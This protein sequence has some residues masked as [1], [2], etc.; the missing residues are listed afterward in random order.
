MATGLSA[1]S[2]SPANP[3]TGVLP[4][5]TIRDFLYHFPMKTAAVLLVCLTSLFPCLAF[6]QDFL[7]VAEFSGLTLTPVGSQTNMSVA[8]NSQHQ[9][10]YA[11]EGNYTHLPI[12]TYSAVGEILD[13]ALSAT[14]FRGVWYNSN[15][16]TFQGNGFS[17][18]GIFEQPV[19]ES[20]GYLLDPG[21]KLFDSNQPLSQSMAAF[22]SAEDQ[23][24]FLAGNKIH[25]HD[26]ATGLFLM[27][28]T[29]SGVSGVGSSVNPYAILYTGIDSAPY[30][31]VDVYVNLLYLLDENA[32]LVQTIALPAEAN[33]NL[34]YGFAWCNNMLWIFDNIQARWESFRIQPAC[35]PEIY[36]ST[37]QIC[38]GRSYSFGEQEL[39]QSGVYELSYQNTLGCDSLIQL[40]LEVMLPDT[41]YQF[42]Q[43]CSGDSIFI[44][45]TWIRSDT[46]VLE[47]IFTEGGCP[48]FVQHSISL[49]EEHPLVVSA[50]VDGR[51]VSFFDNCSTRWKAAYDFGDGQFAS[52][53]NPVHFY[54]QD[55][56]YT[57]K[58]EAKSEYG[59]SYSDAVLISIESLYSENS[60]A[61]T[62]SR[63]EVPEFPT[64]PDPEFPYSRYIYSLNGQ[65][66]QIIENCTTNVQ[67]APD[68]SN[69]PNGI[70]LIHNIGPS[71]NFT[72]KVVVHH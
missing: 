29:I 7:P 20:T 35:L 40:H 38:Q 58:V 3:L 47:S 24:L 1:L 72:E 67:T 19:D 39:D 23:L 21:V 62:A 64:E 28:K 69:I 17:N 11:V 37:A 48:Q 14:D 63:I 4:C 50:S 61:A 56:F 15:T 16:N 65:L 71:V 60:F 70:Y 12:A 41:G 45:D 27:D 66:L 55:G 22:N 6:S 10:Y 34:F 53:T 54:Q 52:Q 5:R 2:K 57:V 68:L 26:A 51:K 42:H 36:E 43:I 31:L 9:V 8:W 46:T 59:C 18:Q 13:T 32:H 25:I 33:P 44:S 30:A 49:F